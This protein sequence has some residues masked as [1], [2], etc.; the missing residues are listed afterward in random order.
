MAL[1]CVERLSPGAE[2]VAL[3]PATRRRAITACLAGNLFEIFDFG[4]YGYFAVQIG[5][6]VFPSADPIASVLASFATYGVGFLMRPIGAM[7]IG[8]YGDRHGRKAALALTITLMAI[9]TGLTGL[10]PTYAQAGLWA[11]IMLLL[12]RLVQGFSTGGEWGGATT[13]LIEHA[14]PG[15]RGFYGSL[16]QV[17]TGLAQIL[18][19]GSALLLNS[20]LGAEDLQAWGWRLPFLLGFVL[21]PIGY[22]LR[23]RVEE[24]PEFAAVSR[25]KRVASAPLRS[26]L[27]VHRGAVLT[28]FG[29]TMI[30]TVSS[31]VFITFMPTFAVHTLGMQPSTALA[32]TICAVLVNVV[33]IPW[34]G[35]AYD[36]WG[37]RRLLIAAA[38]GFALLSVPLFA[39][40]AHEKSLAALAL[41]A[42]VAGV[43]YGI[44]NGAAPALLC[45]LFPTA[46]RYTALSVGY[47][48]AVMVFGGFAPF[49]STVLVRET[50]L[51]I[52]PSFYVA[53]CAAV[54]LGVLT[55]PR[56]RGAFVH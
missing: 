27:T 22:Y 16:Q 44:Y 32:G 28:C 43:F 25:S 2:R 54:S 42:V 35:L 49:V 10:I 8:S 39:F 6:A 19:I 18:S 17:S 37:G 31:Y 15:R 45:T 38:A 20:I 36:R 50:G 55:W 12:C 24:S 23:A 1:D 34:A 53:L 3:G 40:L 48:G 5:R 30:W 46:V 14:P 26:A 56:G 4:V 52:A 51:A 13:F 29:L 33:V 7:V 41:V 21:A 11:P 9:A 47:N